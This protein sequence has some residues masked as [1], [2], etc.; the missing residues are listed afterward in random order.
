MPFLDDRFTMANAASQDLHE[1]FSLARRGDI[2]AYQL[3]FGFRRTHL[4]CF[5]GQ[6]RAISQD[7]LTFILLGFAYILYALT[8]LVQTDDRTIHEELC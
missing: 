4:N 1:K 6:Y 8:R 5:H 2:T 7:I 3:K